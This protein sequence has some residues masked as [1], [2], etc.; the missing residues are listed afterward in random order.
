MCL[1]P[2]SVLQDGTMRV[3]LMILAWALTLFVAANVWARFDTV[4][5][6][7]TRCRAVR[8]DTLETQLQQQLPF[9]ILIVGGVVFLVATIIVFVNDSKTILVTASFAALIAAGSLIVFSLRKP[10]NQLQLTAILATV[11]GFILLSLSGTVNAAPDGLIVFLSGLYVVALSVFVLGVFAT[12][13]LRAGDSWEGPI[14]NATGVLTVTTVMGAIVFLLMQLENF[15]PEIGSDIGVSQAVALLAVLLAMI[16]GLLTIAVVPKRDPFSLSLQ[17][18]QGYVYAAQVVSV[19]SA[20]HLY[21]SMPWLLKTGILQYW[22][23]L[24]IAVS[25]VCLVVSELLKRR[26][27]EVLSEPIFRTAALIPVFVAQGYWLIDSQANAALTFLLGGLIYLGIAVRF[28][29]IWSGVMAMILGN[30]SLWLFYSQQA[31]S[32]TSHPQLWLIPPAV[33]VLLG[34]WLERKRFTQKRLTAIRYG[35]VFALTLSNV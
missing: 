4:K 13:W 8:F 19:I 23:Y 22:P 31:V 28:K 24:A 6:V 30:I 17:G 2:T 15:K 9:W 21:L 35:C 3:T 14:R 20:A 7:A 34:T 27:L 26:G 5:T 11:V 16:L 18:R 12:R 25:L 33:C 1:L 10:A 32:F 29:A